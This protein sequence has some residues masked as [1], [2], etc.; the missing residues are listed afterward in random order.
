M[1][2]CLRKSERSVQIVQKNQMCDKKQEKYE[3]KW[4]VWEKLKCVIKSEIDVWE[5]VRQMW[6]KVRIVWKSKRSLKTWK[7]CEKR[8]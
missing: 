6:E 3:E 8:W 7:M 5:K 2:I 1:D 4:D